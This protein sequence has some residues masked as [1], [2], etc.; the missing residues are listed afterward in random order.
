M[1]EDE[2]ADI[3]R[4]GGTSDIAVKGEKIE[5]VKTMKY[6]WGHCLMEKAHAT[7][8]LNTELGLRRR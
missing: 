1:E 2:G 4:E 3:K 8:R 7:K 6:T 5:E